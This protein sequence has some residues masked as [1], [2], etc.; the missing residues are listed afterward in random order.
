M[1]H[2]QPVDEIHWLMPSSDGQIR[3]MPLGGKSQLRIFDTGHLEGKPMEKKAA[4]YVW[5][6]CGTLLA[7]EHKVNHLHHSS[8]VAGDAVSCA[9]MIRVINGKVDMISNNSGHYKPSVEN[10]EEFAKWLAGRNVFLYESIAILNGGKETHNI[11]DFVMGL[12]KWRPSSNPQVV[13]DLTKLGLSMASVVQR[14]SV[15]TTKNGKYGFNSAWRIKSKESTNALQYLGKDF[16]KDIET[17]KLDMNDS[18]WYN[19]PKEVIRTLLSK[20][21]A[22]SFP[23]LLK[24][25][26][27]RPVIGNRKFSSL[28][29][30]TPLKKSS[31]MHSILSEEF[32]K[33]S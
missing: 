9:G 7:G 3:E 26:N 17:A 23:E 33:L 19:F 1:P 21:G 25:V 27:G 4:A 20:P 2:I 18:S 5:T 12:G 31:T 10:L 14:Y 22:F 8:F 28:A 13:A 24:Q 11:R 6:K 30:L 15:S 16:P 29:G 32:D